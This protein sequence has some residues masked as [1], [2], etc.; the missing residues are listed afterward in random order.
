[1]NTVILVVLLIIAVGAVT[2]LVLAAL[3]AGQ[4]DPGADLRL[5]RDQVDRIRR[6]REGHTGA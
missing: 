6:E 3:C 1:M 4:P 2:A 5:T